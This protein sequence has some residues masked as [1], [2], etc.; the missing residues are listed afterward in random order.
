MNVEQLTTASGLGAQVPAPRNAKVSEQNGSV[1]RGGGIVRR[2]CPRLSPAP[3]RAPAAERCQRFEENMASTPSASGQIRPIGPRSAQGMP[4]V[5]PAKTSK[6][7]GKTALFS[8]GD[9]NLCAR[10]PAPT[11]QV[12]AGRKGRKTQ[13]GPR[14]IAVSVSLVRATSGGLQRPAPSA[15]TGCAASLRQNQRNSREKRHSPLTDER[16]LVR[17]GAQRTGCQSRLTGALASAAFCSREPTGSGKK[18][19][20]PAR[21]A[22]FT[23]RLNA[24]A[25][26]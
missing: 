24:K 14:N 9:G 7:C 23:S 25:P 22:D 10:R 3:R 18:R 20:S 13:K 11:P 1:R 26:V 4:Q 8:R 19:Q 5:R 15:R 17:A 12:G 6:C 21:S 16:Q 2:R